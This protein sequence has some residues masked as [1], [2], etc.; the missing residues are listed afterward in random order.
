MD[1][2]RWHDTPTKG[3]AVFSIATVD[4]NEQREV[5]GMKHEDGEEEEISDVQRE[6]FKAMLLSATLTI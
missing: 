4:Q 6:H 5:K 1:S 3:K 2:D